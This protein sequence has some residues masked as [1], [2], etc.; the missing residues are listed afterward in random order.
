LRRISP[1]VGPFG[2]GKSGY[3]C[4]G[5]AIV[6][7][8]KKHRAGRSLRATGTP[9]PPTVAQQT[10]PAMVFQLTPLSAYVGASWAFRRTAGSPKAA[11]STRGPFRKLTRSYTARDS[12]PWQ[13]ASVAYW[14]SLTL[15]DPTA[16]FV[17]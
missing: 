17:C 11:V 14:L 8:L 3:C 7:L 12:S 4:A 9:Q 10:R 13:D 16:F 15:C 6:G 1:F 2:C 5:G